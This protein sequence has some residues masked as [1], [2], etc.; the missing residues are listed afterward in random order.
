[1]RHP[2]CWLA[3]PLLLGHVPYGEERS[4]L[5]VASLF[6]SSIDRTRPSDRQG[7][8]EAHSTQHTKPA[9]RH[10]SQSGMCHLESNAELQLLAAPC[11]LYKGTTCAGLHDSLQKLWQ[12]HV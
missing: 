10:T 3:R 12:L 7:F 11:T 1:M 8:Q 4:L 9:H 5:E 6:L 2:Y